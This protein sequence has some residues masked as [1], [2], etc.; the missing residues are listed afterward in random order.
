MTHGIFNLFTRSLVL[1]FCSVGFH[2]LG[3]QNATVYNVGSTTMSGGTFFYHY[4]VGAA[5]VVTTSVSS[6]TISPGGS[7][8]FPSRGYTNAQNMFTWVKAGITYYPVLVNGNAFSGGSD[9]STWFNNPADGIGWNVSFAPDGV[10][11]TTYTACVQNS[12]ASP[13]TALFYKNGTL[14]NMAAV[15]AFSQV[16]YT[17]PEVLASDVLNWSCSY[18]SFVSTDTGDG[19]L[20]LSN[21]NL[22]IPGGGASNLTVSGTVTNSTIPPRS[23]STD[24]AN[25]GEVNFGTGA[26]GGATETTLAG[27]INALLQ[28]QNEILQELMNGNGSNQL[29]VTFSNG[30]DTNG[31]TLEQYLSITNPL[32]LQQ[33]AWET[34]HEAQA[35]ASVAEFFPFIGSLGSPHLPQGDQLGTWSL[36]GDSPVSMPGSLGIN[37]GLGQTMTLDPSVA[38][39]VASIFRSVLI[40]VIAYMVF[41]F[42]QVKFNEDVKEILLTPQATTAGQS[43]FGTN[44][45][46][47]GAL[48]MAGLICAVLVAALSVLIPYLL[49]SAMAIS[50]A[51][52]PDTAMLSLGW[53]GQ[54]IYSVLPISYL[55]SGMIACAVYSCVSSAVVVGCQVAI[56]WLTGW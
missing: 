49:E 38:S 27:G 15:G 52:S 29:S 12:S 16:C 28:S 8:Y 6:T 50:A 41:M 45:N 25:G 46:I 19:S 3:A 4:K 55:V 21:L 26:G 7:A 20:N 56:K 47:A 17:Y 32:S 37:I 54:L 22:T 36:P 39:S 48:T 35:G 9:A 34:A 2:A 24:Y 23:S 31:L 40:W 44:L 18:P 11:P 33:A 10:A 30:F 5:A 51:T 13:G 43:V 1:L 14:A 53:G 42:C